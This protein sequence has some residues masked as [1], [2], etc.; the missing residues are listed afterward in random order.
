MRVIVT[1][2]NDDSDAEMNLPTGSAPEYVGALTGQKVSAQGGRIRVRVAANSGE[3]WL[4]AGDMP[5]YKP[6]QVEVPETAAAKEENTASETE[7]K[8]ADENGTVAETAQEAEASTAANTDKDSDDTANPSD[9]SSTTE[10][11]PSSSQETAE[12]VTPNPNKTP[13]EMTV[14]ELQ[15]AILAKMA[16]NG[17][18]DDQ[19]KKTVYDNIW[20]DSL[21]NWLKSFR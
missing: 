15:A 20:H 19:M 17:P 3:I 18:V 5:E 10:T 12:T 11:E 1:V 14:G 13:E 8:P 16:G 6:V 2:N 7:E 4:P 9:V 21:V